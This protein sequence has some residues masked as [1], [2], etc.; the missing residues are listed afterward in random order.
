M[1]KEY[2]LEPDAFTW[3]NFNDRPKPCPK[4]KCDGMVEPT[5][6]AN[7][8]ECNKC[9]EKVAWGHLLSEEEK[10]EMRKNY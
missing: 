6:N 2:P 8:G 7:I 3:E 1:T 5:W 4:K 10:E 9:G